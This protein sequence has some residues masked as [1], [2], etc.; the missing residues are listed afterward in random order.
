MA[1][2]WVLFVGPSQSYRAIGRWMT[3]TKWQDVSTTRFPPS[4]GGVAKRNA[5]AAMAAAENARPLAGL[6]HRPAWNVV[7]AVA[8]RLE[9][10]EAAGSAAS[11]QVATGGAA[12]AAL[13][14]ATS[15]SQC[16]KHLASRNA[17]VLAPSATVNV[18]AAN[19][20]NSINV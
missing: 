12:T 18:T 10:T 4:C 1:S 20:A 17:S 9:V 7:S 6:R 14:P 19:S 5:T 2:A 11:G 13:L 16:L 15:T 8:R 3:Q